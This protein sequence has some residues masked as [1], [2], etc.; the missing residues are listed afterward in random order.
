MEFIEKYISQ[1]G[2]SSPFTTTMI[3]V[4]AVIT[5]A[6][7]VW[8]LLRIILPFIEKRFRKFKIIQ[9]NDQIFHLIKKIIALSVFF[10]AGTVIIDLVN[11]PIFEKIF[12]SLFVLL[13][14]GPLNGIVKIAIHFAETNIASKTISDVD[15]IVIDLLDKFASTI[16]YTTAIIIALD[17]LGVNVMPFIAGAGVAG[18]A[19]GFAAKDTLSNFIAGILLLIDR[20]FELGDRI[21]IW[22]APAGSSTWG[23]VTEIGLRATKISTT[24]NIEVIIPNNEIMT[25]DIINYTATSAS[26]RVRVNIGISYDADITTAK[27][28]INDIAESI[29]WVQA[30]PPPKVVVR[31]FGDSSIDLQLRV[32]IKNA[33]KRMDTISEVTDKIKT[34]FDAAGIE[35]PYPKRDITIVNNDAATK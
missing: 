7:A 6:F 11:I 13:V 5:I 32:W 19:I 12:L 31:N 3:K 16:V 9:L 17:I 21:E 23:D 28:V 20:P 2:I 33:R 18:V 35:I 27:K 22:G 1:L 26:I 30:D 29:E 10:M 8:L 15:N 24:D 14:A 34:A 4:G 25:R